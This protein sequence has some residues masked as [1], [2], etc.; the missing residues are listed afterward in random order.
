MKLSAA[1][2]APGRGVPVLLAPATEAAGALTE[3]SVGNVFAPR[4]TRMSA[5]RFWV[6]YAAESAGALILD[7]GAVRAVVRQRRSLLPAGITGLSGKFFGG[8]VVELRGPDSE[9]VARGVVAYDAAE[10]AAMI[11]RSTPE[12][13]VEMRRPAVHAD[14]LVAV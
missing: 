8:D 13:P 3:A 2:L 12:L 6:R 9:V 10:L 11:G 14:D 7:E 1:P 4:P 5:R